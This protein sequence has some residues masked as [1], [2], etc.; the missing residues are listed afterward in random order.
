MKKRK[1]RKSKKR[2]KELGKRKKRDDIIQDSDVMMKS[3]NVMGI[4]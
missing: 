3:K 2:K 4:I 1:K